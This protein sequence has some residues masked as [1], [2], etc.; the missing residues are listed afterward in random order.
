MCKYCDDENCHLTKEQV[1]QHGPILETNAYSIM[2]SETDERPQTYAFEG[3]PAYNSLTAWIPDEDEESPHV[4]FRHDFD[5]DEECEDGI[6]CADIAHPL[7]W[8]TEK[9]FLEKFLGSSPEGE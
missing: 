9:A 2:R 8:Q 3:V 1:L 5:E 7:M 6:M 4:Y